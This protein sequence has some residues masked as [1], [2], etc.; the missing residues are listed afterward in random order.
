MGV[1]A[2]E[3]KRDHRGAP[4]KYQ[5]GMLEQSMGRFL[6]EAGGDVREWRL[7]TFG[8]EPRVQRSRLDAVSLRTIQSK[9]WAYP[10]LQFEALWNYG[11]VRHARDPAPG[12]FP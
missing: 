11:R 12:Y 10:S 2:G 4:A 6:G 8:E 9:G 1:F 7:R 5:P 3:P